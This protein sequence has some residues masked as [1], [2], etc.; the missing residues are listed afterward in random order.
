M[1]EEHKEKVTKVSDLLNTEIW[2]KIADGIEQSGQ[3]RPDYE[4]SSVEFADMELAEA[5][6]PRELLHAV[7]KV[8]QTVD[9]FS[10]GGSSRPYLVQA[11]SSVANAARASAR[12]FQR[13]P[14]DSGKAARAVLAE[15]L[16][17]L[18]EAASAVAIEFQRQQPKDGEDTEAAAA[19]ERAV[20]AFRTACREASAAF[21][22][23]LRGSG[24]AN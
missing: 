6:A 1:C 24:G 10:G 18:A 13:Y 3:P 20:A 17:T 8:V 14:G 7:Q 16:V 22:P 9:V 23:A 15:R 2:K 5:A 11:A 19:S 21:L 12:V 4:T